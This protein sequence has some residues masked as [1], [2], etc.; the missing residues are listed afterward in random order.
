MGLRDDIQAQWRTG[1]MLVRLI[2]INIG[3]FVALRL[4]GL[5]FFLFGTGGP[6]VLQWLMSTSHPGRL[7]QR[8][9]T[10]VTYMFTHWDLFHLLF[11]MLVLYYIGRI[12]LD[13]LGPKRLLGNYLLG[14][15]TGLALY[16]LAYNL[17]PAFQR[18]AQDS[19]ILGASAAVMG[20]FIGIAAYRPEVRIH[21]LLFGAVQLKWLALIYVVI[22]LV[23]IQH[24]GNSGG[25]I[26]HLGGALYGYLAARQLA[27][28]ND[29]SMRFVEF[30]ERAGRLFKGDRR[31]RMR[32]AK[33][34][35][36]NV[37]ERDAE[38][39]AR[40]A[41]MQARVDA[42]LD[43]ISRSGYESLSKEEKDLLFKASK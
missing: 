21:L 11:N 35:V 12:F 7:V 38:F 15:F 37:H 8:P 14:G 26:A 20:V 30:L 29:W 22:D 1:G 4:L 16:V 13:L 36:R 18:F 5:V 43:K 27:Q 19:T 41:D 39:N 42:I 6:D 10:V 32:V 31:P 24:G 9:W 2:F 40:K 33:K 25:H 3:V 17:L 34:P 23:S 28:G